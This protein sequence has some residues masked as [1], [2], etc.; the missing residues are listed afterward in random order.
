MTRK[1]AL[2]FKLHKLQSSFKLEGQI[3]ADRYTKKLTGNWTLYNNILRKFKNTIVFSRTMSTE[4]MVPSYYLESIIDAKLQVP[5]AYRMLFDLKSKDN[6][7]T[8]RFFI[9]DLKDQSSKL[10]DSQL[11][12]D[13]TQELKQTNGFYDVN[14]DFLV[15]FYLSFL[16]KNYLDLQA[17]YAGDLFQNQLKINSKIDDTN[18]YFLNYKFNNSKIELLSYELSIEKESFNFTRS[19]LNSSLNWVI[20]ENTLFVDEI[21]A[22]NNT[23]NHTIDFKL[24]CHEVIEQN[25]HFK[26]ISQGIYRYV[27]GSS[28]EGASL[29]KFDLIHSS[30]NE[31]ANVY[32]IEM[33]SSKVSSFKVAKD[34]IDLS[35]NKNGN[36]LIKYSGVLNKELGEFKSSIHK[37]KSNSAILNNFELK[38]LANVTNFELEFIDLTASNEIGANKIL[39]SNYPFR[40]EMYHK[41]VDTHVHIFNGYEAK[42][43]LKNKE[44]DFH[45]NTTILDSGRQD[46]F[47]FE[48]SIEMG[49]NFLDNQLFEMKWNMQN[50]LNGEFSSSVNLVANRME[51]YWLPSYE[52]TALVDSKSGNLLSPFYY[53]LFSDLTSASNGFSSRLL[54]E[55]L[56][57][58][59]IVKLV[60]LSTGFYRNNATIQDSLNYTIL[61]D[62]KI[63]QRISETDFNLQLKADAVAS[64]KKSLFSLFYNTSEPMTIK[65]LHNIEET[66]TSSEKRIGFYIKTQ[67]EFVDVEKQYSLVAK[68]LN[69][70]GESQKY[71]AFEFSEEDQKSTNTFFVQEI[72]KSHPDESWTTKHSIGLT[73]SA[74]YNL[75]EYLSFLAEPSDD[76][77]SLVLLFECGNNVSLG[78]YELN[79]YLMYNDEP[80]ASTR[81]NY[82]T[83]FTL[84]DFFM[85]EMAKKTVGANFSFSVAEYSSMIAAELNAEFSKNERK[86]NT[87]FEMKANSS[88]AE[89]IQLTRLNTEVM[90]ADEKFKARFSL[91]PEG[92]DTEELKLFSHGQLKL[93]AVEP[94]EIELEYERKMRD[95]ES[96]SATGVVKYK[97]TDIWNFEASVLVN[98]YFEHVL[99]VKNSHN[100]NNFRLKSF[101]FDCQSESEISN[102]CSTR[103]I[104]VLFEEKEY[105]I[106]TDDDYGLNFLLNW[107]S[108]VLS[109][110]NILFKLNSTIY[111]T[112]EFEFIKLENL[113]D[114]KIYG[115]DYNHQS[116]LTTYSTVKLNMID[117]FSSLETNEFLEH[118]V[119]FEKDNANIALSLNSSMN[120]D[121][122]QRLNLNHNFA[123]SQKYV[124][125]LSYEMPE[126]NFSFGHEFEPGLSPEFYLIFFKSS[127]IFLNLNQSFVQTLSIGDS[128]VEATDCEMVGIYGDEDAPI[129]YD[130]VYSN[131]ARFGFKIECNN[132]VFTNNI[133]TISNDYQRSS[134]SDDV[135]FNEKS[136]QFLTNSALYEQK[137]FNITRQASNSF[138]DSYRINI[139]NGESSI[140]IYKSIKNDQFSYGSLLNLTSLNTYG[141]TFSHSESLGKQVL[142]VIL[143]IRTIRG[144]LLCHK[145]SNGFTADLYWD[146]IKAPSKLIT[147][148]LKQGELTKG[149]SFLVID[150]SN[151]PSFNFIKLELNQLRSFN[152]TNLNAVFSYELKSLDANRLEV[153]VKTSSNLKSN[154]YFYETSLA[155]PNTHVFFEGRFDKNSGDLEAMELRTANLF[156]FVVE[157]MDRNGTQQISLQ[158]VNPNVNRYTFE[159]KTHK[160]NNVYVVEGTLKQNSVDLSNLMSKF[161]SANNE[162]ELTLN[163]IK[164]NKIYRLNA[165]FFNENIFN[166]ILMDQTNDKVL[167]KAE[168]EI[169]QEL[170][171]NVEWHDFWQLL[172]QDAL[173][174]D[175]IELT[176]ENILKIFHDL[177]PV[178]AD[179]R[180]EMS[181]FLSDFS[182]D[183]QDALTPYRPNTMRLANA[184]YDFT[185]FQIDASYSM[186]TKNVT[187]Y[188]VVLMQGRSQ[189]AT[190]EVTKNYLNNLN[191]LE[192][193][194]IEFQRNLNIFRAYSKMKYYLNKIQYINIY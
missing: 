41:E 105:K 1:V 67:D 23:L 106:V 80:L 64:W 118:I 99:L 170:K 129:N 112:R 143:P 148:N 168:L 155:R 149:Q 11:T 88:L 102:E 61:V 108:S 150:V 27:Y 84:D 9:E 57:N 29:I 166:A 159:G 92:G 7:I 56:D 34:Q 39:N 13:S 152:Q 135:L 22:S 127:R 190:I 68:T 4:S 70:E 147:F 65:L 43:D 177:G 25:I 77:K 174:A 194:N 125:S 178:Y 3:S 101:N 138:N 146:L 44:Y 71:Y 2:E 59:E 182:I 66:L 90:I 171:M 19:L 110:E 5:V 17:H 140:L 72:R 52:F 81:A 30:N 40:I 24:E 63:D 35:I 111:W 16:G 55:K 179:S 167:L 10:V 120:S 123:N 89:L 183:S 142:D 187:Y 8:S 145:D 119:Y 62:A 192:L 164:A 103:D 153:T 79:S 42:F 76:L 132:K 28:M 86:L 48:S 169:N 97:F 158:L 186:S 87:Q 117:T 160:K 75:E 96:K 83:N 37:F 94:A 191:R 33:N 109:Q 189:L 157:K 161:D 128:Q 53:K 121:Y 18:T 184:Y 162:F 78:F 114:S 91:A 165:G 124:T 36:E 172:K 185:L 21:N 137:Q 73:T 188:E 49:N 47:K 60:D 54:A 69:N 193:T 50:K 173:A 32:L 134:D 100:Q 12:F 15:K 85:T 104:N 115:F 126:L 122:F 98:K 163:A 116:D 136:I 181:V 141:V 144:S 133:M 156:K 74:N 151:S 46:L 95:G 113:L 131:V 130:S 31:K 58:N 45:F 93:D 176:N 26:G 180:R 139:V 175:N 38:W 82:Y 6:T 107:R 154:Y 20:K 51:I 14:F